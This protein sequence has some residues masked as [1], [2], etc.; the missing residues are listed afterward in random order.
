MP[1]DVYRAGFSRGYHTEMMWC[2]GDTNRFDVLFVKQAC[3]FEY[4]PVAIAAARVAGIYPGTAAQPLISYTNKAAKEADSKV[5]DGDLRATVDDIRSYKTFLRQ[6]LP[7]Y[8][9]P[10]IFM[11]AHSFA[12]TNNAKVDRKKLPLP[13]SEDI[14]TSAGHRGN[15]EDYVKP[16]GHVQE[17]GG[18]AA[19]WGGANV[20]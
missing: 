14:A 17:V 7:E 20:G 2:I 9:V 6:S 12:K 18:A 4:E 8:M 1:E 15:P 3:K 13:T 19:A 16:E 10:S 5:D 11:H